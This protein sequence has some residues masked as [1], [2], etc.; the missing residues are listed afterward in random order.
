[1]TYQ[2][3]SNVTSLIQLFDYVQRQEAI[4]G[5][6]I[7]L[8]TFVVLFFAMKERFTTSRAFSGSMFVTFIVSVLLRVLTLIDNEPMI[9]SFAG[10]ILAILYLKYEEP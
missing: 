5:S 7:L 3:V 10:L 2:N 4:F 1:M 8:T 9:I 6:V